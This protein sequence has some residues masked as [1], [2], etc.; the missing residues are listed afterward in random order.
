MKWGEVGGGWSCVRTGMGEKTTDR[1]E[2]N[3]KA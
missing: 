1:Q 3:E 2:S